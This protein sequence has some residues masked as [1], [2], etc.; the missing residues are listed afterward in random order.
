MLLS[1]SSTNTIDTKELTSFVYGIQICTAFDIRRDGVEY[2]RGGEVEE[3]EKKKLV[4]NHLEEE[5]IM[6]IRCCGT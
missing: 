2:K 6:M 5:E 3:K 1:P 4:A